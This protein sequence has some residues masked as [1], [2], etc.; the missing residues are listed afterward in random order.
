MAAG[1][2][3]SGD[4]GLVLGGAAGED[5]RTAGQFGEFRVGE[6]VEAVGGEDTGHRD[7]Q[8]TAGPDRGA[9]VVAGEDLDGDAPSGEPGEGL[10]GGGGEGVPE[11]DQAAEGEAAFLGAGPGRAG[12]GG[13]R[14]D[15]QPVRGLRVGEVAQTG[16]LVVGQGT[17]LQYGVHGALGDLGVRAE[18]AWGADDHGGQAAGRV[19]GAGRDAVVRHEG[20]L[21]GG[22]EQGLVQGVGGREVGELE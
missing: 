17:A 8:I 11:G 2:E 4:P 3:G 5:G 14:E 21:V 15:A 16:A 18:P 7:A 1:L 12:G 19:E 22:R 6:G 9:R 10:G 20:V 13:D